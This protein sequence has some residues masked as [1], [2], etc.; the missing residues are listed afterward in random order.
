MIPL[1]DTTSL[2]KLPY[3]TVLFMAVILVV[4]VI[5][6]FQPDFDYTVHRFGLIPL[7]FNPE[8]AN[9][10]FVLTSLFLHAN[11]IHAAVNVYF[12]H[13]FGYHVEDRLGH[14]AF[15]L[16]MLMAGFMALMLQI[17]L[18]RFTNL[19]LVG[20][21]GAVTALAGTYV[22]FQFWA[23]VR[24]WLPLPGNFRHT[25]LAPSWTLVLMWFALQ[26]VVYLWTMGAVNYNI[27]GTAWFAHV[28]GFLF[29]AA[30]GLMIR[31]ISRES[32]RPAYGKSQ[33]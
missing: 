20:S 25:F 10:I 32:R 11:P 18:V 6:L 1:Y 31:A 26:N 19:P 17:T 12:L 28:G 16:Y 15:L 27:G 29:G 8:G 21:S 30:M 23:K 14:L 3:V 9:Y 13:L 22:I 33:S 24:V 4:F 5:Q 7:L 2:R